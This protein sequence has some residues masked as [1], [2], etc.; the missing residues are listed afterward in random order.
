[1]FLFLKMFMD[2]ICQTPELL[3]NE[4]TMAFLKL[5]DDKK[6]TLKKKE[7]EYLT[8]PSKITEILNIEGSIHIKSN[9]ENKIFSHYVNEYLN[10]AEPIYLKYIKLTHILIKILYFF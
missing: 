8:K 10:S 4:F 2:L 9:K 7:S 1:M 3:Y 5:N 6:L